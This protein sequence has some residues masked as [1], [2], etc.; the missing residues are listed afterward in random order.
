MSRIKRVVVLVFLS[1]LSWNPLYSQN[2]SSIELKE[3][4]DL[5]QKGFTI[6]KVRNGYQDGVEILGKAENIFKKYGDWKLYLTA[7]NQK[8]ECMWRVGLWE[9]A[10][11][12]CLQVLDE[13]KKY[14]GEDA[15]V[16]ADTYFSLGAIANFFDH[17]PGKTV[18][19]AQQG[20]QILSK[21]EGEPN[22]RYVRLY[23]LIGN[24]SSDI[25]VARQSYMKA[26]YN[27]DPGDPFERNVYVN[28][29]YSY[30]KR[31][32]FAR[33]SYYYQKSLEVKQDKDG[34]YAG[35]LEILAE[36]QSNL[37]QFRQAEKNLKESLA[38]KRKLFGEESEQ[39]AYNYNTQGILYS[40][41][42]D[43]LKADSIVQKSYKILLKE[44]GEEYPAT[45]F[46]IASRGW[47]FILLGQIEESIKLL[48]KA[49]EL[50]EKVYGPDNDETLTT[51]NN[52]AVAYRFHRDFE[53][54]EELEAKLIEIAKEKGQEHT[55]NFAVYHDT[56]GLIYYDWGRYDKALPYLEKSLEVWKEVY[57]DRHPEYLQTLNNLARVQ[58]ALGNPDQAIKYCKEVV[59]KGRELVGE[60]YRLLLRFHNPLG[61]AYFLRGDKKD[62]A[63]V[64]NADNQFYLSYIDRYF[65]GMGESERATFYNTFRNYLDSYRSF[66]TDYSQETKSILNDF[67]DFQLQTK[68]MLLNTSL[69]VKN[70]IR[71]SG[72]E[73]ALSLFNEI[74]DLKQELGKY[75][76]ASPDE[77]KSK[78]INL[79]SLTEVLNYKERDL[80][81]LSAD[82]A[83]SQKKPS[84]RDIRDKLEK[85][86]AAVE[87]VR[88]TNFDFQKQ[89]QSDSIIYAALVVRPKMKNP[90][91]IVFPAGNQFEKSFI[92]F[93]KNAIRFKLDDK[94]SYKEFWNPLTPYLK[95]VKTVYIASDGVYHQINLNTL[96]DTDEK[97][98]LIDEY[99]ITQVSSLQDILNPPRQPSADKEAVLLGNPDFSYN[100]ND[101]DTIKVTRGVSQLPGTEAEVEGI[102]HLLTENGWIVEYMEGDSALEENL[103]DIR[104]PKVLHLATH[105][106]FE[107]DTKNLTI[108]KNP[109]FQSGLLLAGANYSLANR[110]S[111]GLNVLQ[112]KEDG[113][114]TAYEAMALDVNNTDLVTLSACETGLGEVQNGEGVYGLQR[115]LTIAG[116]KNIIM[117]LW[118]VNDEVTQQLMADFYRNWLKGNDIR[119]AFTKAQNEI[120]KRYPQPYYWG[121]FILIGK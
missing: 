49:R 17:N 109:L 35:I 100:E 74:Q 59:S 16:T 112:G 48:T 13:A 117:S 92:K 78:G 26:I 80:T 111:A 4:N 45:I 44:R 2:G 12:E 96:F 83:R 97:K 89:Q 7:R 103:K 38:I 85:D 75:L 70:S 84:W 61:N 115:A 72:N 43:Y 65:Q 50:Q 98:Y 5:L 99:N 110:E 114:F 62:A 95:G 47:W 105:G 106:F 107:K 102:G 21:Y 46:G 22:N 18:E 23:N 55:E 71:S 52:L 118:K 37:G 104:S 27:M 51:I 40:L 77:L 82:Y 53:K 57:G 90:Q 73:Q 29:A 31:S 66:V 15:E 116:A 113:I 34:F 20:I 24:F 101:S 69:S 39:I 58:L 9:G 88:M 108:G 36:A 63:E 6:L 94:I 11:K 54:A 67:M 91:L 121:A 1:L 81:N 120:K 28:V 25:E 41:K 3:A 19:Y 87:L 119:R 32:E 79:D 76:Q 68:S 33:A 14:F 64:F 56:M 86:Q 93:Y 10:K 8:I 60:N 42:G 30:F